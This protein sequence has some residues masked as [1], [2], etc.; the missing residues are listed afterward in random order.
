[1]P[2]YE[3][4]FRLHGVNYQETMPRFSNNMTL[5]IKLLNMLFEED[6][7]ALLG[8]ALQN[9]DVAQA[10]AHAHTIKGVLGNMGLSQ[11]YA[12]ACA[13]VEPLSAKQWQEEEYTALYTRLCA[14]YEEARALLDALKKA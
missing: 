2:T 4:I 7:L 3:E 6:T 14:Q 9:K 8:Q 12:T 13:L 10:F 11:A 5:Y 1:M